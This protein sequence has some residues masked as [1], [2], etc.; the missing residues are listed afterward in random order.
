MAERRNPAGWLAWPLAAAL[1]T[2]LALAAWADPRPPDGVWGLVGWLVLPPHWRTLVAVLLA[3]VVAPPIAR[4]LA[5]S[6]RRLAPLA[7]RV[8]SLPPWLWVCLLVALC[9]L[10][11]SQR[12]YGDAPTIVEAIQGG[13]WINHKEPLD[14]LVTSALYRMGHAAIGWDAITA[15]A[16]V[17]T[18]VGALYWTGVAR[19]ARLPWFTGPARPTAALLVAA[20][21]AVQLFCGYV[22]SYSFLAAGTVWTLTLCLEAAG[23]SRRRLWPA[24]AAYGVTF[25]SHLAAAWLAGAPI[26]TWAL[27][28]VRRRR[29]LGDAPGHAR[30]SARE[31]V[32]GTVVASAPIAALAAA[33]MVTEVGLGGF[34]RVSFGGGDGVMFVPLAAPT[35]AMERFTMFSW[36]HLSAFANQM[37]LLAP[38][39]VAVVVVCGPFL[40]RRRAAT[41]P[42]AAVLVPAV[43]GTV[44]YAF[45]FNPDLMVYYPELGPLVEWDLFSVAAVPLAMLAATW[46]QKAL[47]EEL[48]GAGAALAAGS[49]AL[50]HSALWVVYN[51]AP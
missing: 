24:A 31:A 29:E 32:I 42:A 23:D 1:W 41:G 51:A 46:L 2:I 35:T 38:V 50:A 8:R 18:L 36:Q 25:A 47:E 3:L 4:R 13:Q 26:A 27:R 44:L 37:L 39:G 48:A 14:R 22:E 12:F 33:M 34:S 21:A 28:A 49:V 20:T 5:D 15:I 40:L 43:V 10:L 17:N 6:L 7:D 11:R 30:I 9:W 19:F 16:L 45:V